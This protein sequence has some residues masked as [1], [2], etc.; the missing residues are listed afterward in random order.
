MF[1]LIFVSSLFSY[2]ATNRTGSLNERAPHPVC[3]S[4]VV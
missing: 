3:L 4:V 1:S 2:A